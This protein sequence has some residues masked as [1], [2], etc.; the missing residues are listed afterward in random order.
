MAS[1]NRAI[2]GL[3]LL[4]SLLML[5]GCTQ[6][7]ASTLKIGVVTTQTGVGAYQGQQALRGLELATEQINANGGVNG[8]QVQLII[9][10]SKAEPATAVTATK[11]LIQA[12][13]VKFIIGDS[14]TSTTVVMV[15]LTNENQVILVSP[16]ATLDELSK[17]DYF[18]RTM[19]T[20]NSMMVPLADYAYNEM[21]LRAV[22]ILRQQ[23]PFG[24][25]HAND[26]R[27]EFERL[28]GTIVGEESFDLKQSDV[29]SEIGKI[30]EK[31]PDSILNLH[32]TGPMMGV[33]LKQAKELDLNVKALGTFGTENAD[34]LRDYGDV[35]EGMVYPYP[36]NTG[37]DNPGAKAFVQAYQ[38]KF[39]N[40][41]DNTA[42]NAYDALT[43][44]A[45][46]IS[47]VGEDSAKV[48]S[49]LLTIQNF[50]GAGGL[51]SF[52]EFGDVQKNILIKIVQNGK[53]VLLE[54]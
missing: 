26:F 16:Q 48:K 17:D 9:E 4:V 21:G 39:G 1:K 11:K 28:G 44:L 38:N 5:A 29:R 37:L 32:A 52:N 19:P 41:P 43:V 36:Y 6:P 10:D 20:T 23:T 54:E 13:G 18:F 40:A 45:N 49:H 35:I 7:N 22:G 24:V 3:V 34:L 27:A 46:A 8:K 12:D 51:L 53:F 30:K 50:D 42:A 33:L 31:N 47:T 14:W 2:I 25:E 15:P